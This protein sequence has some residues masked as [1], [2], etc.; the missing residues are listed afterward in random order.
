MAN[1]NPPGHAARFSCVK[2]L[3]TQMNPAMSMKTKGRTTN[4]SFR[5]SRFFSAGKDPLENKNLEIDGA[6]GDIYEK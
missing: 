1:G 5:T 2:D 4:S 6:S 3:K